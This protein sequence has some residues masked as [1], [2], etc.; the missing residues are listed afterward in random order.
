MSLNHALRFK[1]AIA[2]VVLVS[3]LSAACAPSRVGKEDRAPDPAFVVAHSDGIVSRFADLSVVLSSGRDADALRGVNP[4]SFEPPIAGTASWSADGSRLDFKP[5]VPLEAGETYR[6][7]FD[8]ASIGEPSNGWFSF[9]IRAAEP[10]LSVVPGA[11]YAAFD[12]SLSL[13]GS[14][15]SD[16]APASAD[17]ERL[18]SATLG[19]RRL[20][21]SWSHEGDGLH[22][23]TVKRIPR[24][25]RESTL[26]LSWDGQIIGASAKG[27]ER[28]RIPAE[29]SFELL[30]VTGP[31]PGESACL[32]LAFSEPVDKA[33][34]F[35]GLIRTS[36]S[37]TS[38]P[39]SLRYESEGGLV[40]VYSS[41]GWSEE[42]GVTV[43][44]GLRGLSGG[45]IAV[46]VDSMA[47]A[48]EL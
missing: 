36:S 23:F 13:D 21:L 40:R 48:P 43:E 34:D 32:R 12:G 11:L 1:A 26:T 47:P 39:G 15:R 19:G 41:L 45:A 33:Q 18:V 8:F 27:S 22:R 9:R 38:S 4:L 24:S 16:D 14:L 35:R 30:S 20:D 31:E 5:A 42:V 44:K 6:A 3:T 29:G 2:A 28:Y 17:V 25:V 46:P 37:D 10:G 7:V